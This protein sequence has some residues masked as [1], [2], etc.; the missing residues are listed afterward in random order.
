MSTVDRLVGGRAGL[1][2]AVSLDPHGIVIE[3]AGQ[4]DAE[5]LAATVY[6]CQAA[7]EEATAGLGLGELKGWIAVT[8][9]RAVYACPTPNG[10][11]TALGPQ[12][13][14]VIAQLDGVV[15]TAGGIR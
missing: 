9:E 4:G 5:S 8:E 13:R 11:M 7:V 3:A 1:E 10:S 6:M 2:L 15:R 14:T 12:S